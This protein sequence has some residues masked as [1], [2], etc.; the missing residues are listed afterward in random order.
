MPTETF[1]M[2]GPFVCELLYGVALSKFQRVPR[3][4]RQVLYTG[5]AIC[6]PGTADL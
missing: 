6:A 2:I 5:V 3:A 1:H 4:G